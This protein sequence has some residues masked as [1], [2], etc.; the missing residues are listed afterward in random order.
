MKKLALLFAG[1]AT[2]SFA[3]G[4]HCGSCGGGCG[5][6]G[7]GVP[8]YGYGGGGCATGNCGT[9]PGAYPYGLAPQGMLTPEVNSV[10]ANYPIAPPVYHSTFAQPWG[11]TYPQ[12]A[13]APLEP[14]PTY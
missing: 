10:Q 8:A 9:A 6:Q 13:V 7:Y 3:V 12:T 14:L 11:V 1:I 4:C 2:M 5:T